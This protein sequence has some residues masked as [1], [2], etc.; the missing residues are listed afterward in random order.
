MEFL[1]S[2]WLAFPLFAVFW[3]TVC[4]ILSRISGWSALA[5]FYA[6]SDTPEGRKFSAQSIHLG[7]GKLLRASYGG[8]VTAHLS[9][10]AL[11]LKV[12]PLFSFGHAKLRIPLEDIQVE[13]SRLL[14]FTT[15]G[16]GFRRFQKL[17]MH[18]YGN[19]GHGLLNFK[20]RPMTAGVSS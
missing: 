14:F 11:Y 4:F 9:E 1:K 10:K 19:L 18:V 15:V 20:T 13:R 6:S 5:L 16:V 3:C 12:M 8:I 17:R 2:P 7:Y